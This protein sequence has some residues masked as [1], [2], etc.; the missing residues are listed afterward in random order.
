MCHADVLKSPLPSANTGTELKARMASTQIST[1]PNQ[2]QIAPAT[3]DLSRKDAA[4]QRA[5]WR[6]AMTSAAKAHKSALSL[7]QALVAAPTS[8][9]ADLPALDADGR[10]ASHLK[11]VSEP[12]KPRVHGVDAGECDAY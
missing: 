6:R 7:H 9:A 3:G 12:E 1:L 2:G 11:T 5:K 10:M 8:A 4:A